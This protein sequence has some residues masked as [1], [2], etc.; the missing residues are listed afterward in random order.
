[1]TDVFLLL[2]QPNAGDDLQAMKKGV[3]EFADFV[4]I[5]KCDLDPDA[6]TRAQASMVSTLRLMEGSKWVHAGVSAMPDD[7]AL[8]SM[9]LAPGAPHPKPAQETAL[10]PGAMSYSIEARVHQISALKGLGV[11][12]LMEGLFAH[13]VWMKDQGRWAPKRQAQAL[14]WLWERVYSGLKSSFLDSSA[15]KDELPELLK[16]VQ[17]GSLAPST[18]ARRLI[19]LYRG[20]QEA[21]YPPRPSA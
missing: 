17:R 9:A 8:Q 1:M 6:A 2:Q 15:V 19:G 12:A 5:N 11:Q 13:R 3:M 14:A 16:Q 7:A 10:G 20:P 21:G 18:A 4:A